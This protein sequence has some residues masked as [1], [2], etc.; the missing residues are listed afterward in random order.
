MDKNNNNKKKSTTSNATEQ[1]SYDLSILKKYE[2]IYDQEGYC[3]AFS[4]DQLNNSKTSDNNNN[5]ET[6]PLA[7]F[8]HFGFLVI[9]N[10]LT[11]DECDRTL[12][13]IFGIMESKSTFKRDDRSTWNDFPETD[14]IVQ[15]GSPSRPPIF[16]RQFLL[17]RCN[18]N[19][20]NVFA[21]VLGNQDLMTNHDRCCFF[22][23]TETD[24]TSAD[25]IGKKEWSTK[26]NVHLDMNPFNW[27]MT[28][29]SVVRA[30]LDRLRYDKISEFIVENNQPSHLDGTQLQGVINLLD[31]HLEDGGYCV[32]PGFLHCFEEYFKTKT[33]NY[34]QPSTNFSSKDPVF[35]Y[36]RRIPMRKGSVVVWDQRMPHGSLSNHSSNPRSAQFIKMFPTTTVSQDRYKSRAIVLS[37]I[38]NSIDDFPSTPLS[39]QL[40]G[41]VGKY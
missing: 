3:L 29:G 23:P 22:R 20:F 5:V 14:S 2:L 8:N 34:T 24:S 38:I 36:A 37:K 25:K 31:N 39:N 27:M 19:I 1:S 17:N 6:N 7:F 28:D 26:D 21:T 9:E 12:G 30:E 41:L 32:V 40:F 16:T 11:S 18:P 33:P 4:L 10:A 35:K 13:E 15:Y